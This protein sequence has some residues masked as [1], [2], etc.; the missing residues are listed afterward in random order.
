MP[1]PCRFASLLVCVLAGCVSLPPEGPERHCPAGIGPA[2]R[3]LPGRRRHVQELRPRG[4]RTADS[5]AGGRRCR[6]GERRDR[7]A[8][9]GGG[10]SSHQRFAGSRRRCR[11]RPAG[12]QHGGSGRCQRIESGAA[13]TLR[14]ELRAVHVRAW[15]QG[16]ADRRR[17]RQGRECRRL[18][19]AP[20]T[21]RPAATA[22]ARGIPATATTLSS[23]A[24]A[25]ASGPALRGRASRANGTGAQQG[26]S[27]AG[28]RCEWEKGR[29]LA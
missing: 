4:D 18:P 24:P 20:P 2:L 17:R 10:R 23:L 25:L 28:C 22:S 5:C 15:P 21:G 27:T 3:D 13:A 8:C 7:H 1:S 14:P 6:C 12:G 11:R 19:A 16:S 29:L 9:R 26:E